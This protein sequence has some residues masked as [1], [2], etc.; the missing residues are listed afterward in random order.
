MNTL[1]ESISPRGICVNNG[2]AET[3][4]REVIDTQY[5]NYADGIIDRNRKLIFSDI[6]F[7]HISMDT[8]KEVEFRIST[9][10]PVIEMVFSLS[11]NTT[12]KLEGISKPLEQQV[13]H[14]NVLYYPTGY[15]NIWPKGSNLEMISILLSPSLMKRNI[16]DSKPFQKFLRS[17][18][19]NENAYLS[20]SGLPLTPTMYSLLQEIIQHKRNGLFLRMHVEA[21]ILE[22]LMLQMEQMERF[23]SQ[24]KPMLLSQNHFNQ[25]IQAREFIENN[26]YSQISIAEISSQIG[27]NEFTLRRNFKQIFGKTVH[28]FQTEVRMTEARKL[29]LAE[30]NNVNEVAHLLGYNDSTNFT[31]A[32]KKH[33]GYTP[34]KI[35]S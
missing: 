20:K 32:F 18:E 25:I 13:N 26:M 33:F 35:L 2:F 30:H 21:T 6:S 16:P 5:V 10:S 1:V 24:G 19:A 9:D 3:E 7:V 4:S 17:I 8:E 29:L 27:T 15:S 12:F 14:H 28:A 22:L 23:Y 11:T 31:A 34:G